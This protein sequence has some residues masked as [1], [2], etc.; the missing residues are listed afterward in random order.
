[1]PHVHIGA[2]EFAIFGLMLLIWMAFLRIVE[3]YT[4]ETPVGRALAFVH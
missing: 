2:A 1:M 4:H 3:M